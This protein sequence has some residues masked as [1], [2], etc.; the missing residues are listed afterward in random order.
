ML[1]KERMAGQKG[2]SIVETALILPI[3]ILI[4]TGII[5]FGLMFNNYLVITNASR[6]AARNAAVGAT[7][8]EIAVMVANMTTSLN[9]S[10]LSTTIYP[11]QALRKK[12]DEVVV[13][14]EYDNALLTPI[15][16]SIIPNPLHLQAKT[17]MRM[18]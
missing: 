17:T 4:L 5:D 10:K 8:A 18:E 6:E 15:I 16:S 9:S 14:I 2:Q 3:I 12:G 1:R 11:G 13:T 7:D